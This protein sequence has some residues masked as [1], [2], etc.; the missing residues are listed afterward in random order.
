MAAIEA[1]GKDVELVCKTEKVTSLAALSY[2]QY[3]RWMD[4]CAKIKK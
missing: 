4:N 3:K 2:E 1:A